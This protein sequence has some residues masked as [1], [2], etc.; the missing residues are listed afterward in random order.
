MDFPNLI[1]TISKLLNKIIAQQEINLSLSGV[2]QSKGSLRRQAAQ[3]KILLASCN[4]VML[5][6]PE[7]LSRVII[8]DYQYKI[9][10]L[11]LT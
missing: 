1:T 5:K 9:H 7:K 8:L 3:N 10:E 11:I 2:P 6:H 4:Q